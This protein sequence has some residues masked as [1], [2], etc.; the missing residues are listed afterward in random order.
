MKES[1]EWEFTFAQVDSGLTYTGLSQGSDGQLAEVNLWQ[2]SC[3]SRWLPGTWPRHSAKLP[4]VGCSEMCPR[5]WL[6]SQDGIGGGSECSPRLGYM[7]F[8]VAQG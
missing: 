4:K 5:V 1:L 3:C 2:V 7:L 8:I 6:E